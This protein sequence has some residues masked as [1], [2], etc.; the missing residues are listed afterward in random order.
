[1]VRWFLAWVAV[2]FL[3]V[4]ALIAGLGLVAL[5]DFHGCGRDAAIANCVNG[6][7]YDAWGLVALG[8]VLLLVG[9]VALAIAF[10]NARFDAAEP[11][12]ADRSD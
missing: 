3:L 11:Y 1:M 9:V 6:V 7:D 12:E 4:G 2:A 5:H 8:A 10:R